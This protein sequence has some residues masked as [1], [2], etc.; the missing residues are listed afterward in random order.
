MFKV[1]LSFLLARWRVAPWIIHSQI[2][3]SGLMCA[4]CV[5]IDNTTVENLRAVCLDHAKLGENSLSPSLDSRFFGPSPSQVLYLIEVRLS[6][7]H[8]MLSLP[9]ITVLYW[10]GNS[11]VSISTFIHILKY[12]ISK[13]DKNGAI[14]K[15]NFL[16]FARKLL[17]WLQV[18]F[19][20]S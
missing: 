19:G 9:F 17:C 12:L 4:V 15:E 16:I 5:Y 14:E 20:F 7:V 11:H 10:Q 18:V 13:V 6:L 2:Y 1:L 3:V 8:A